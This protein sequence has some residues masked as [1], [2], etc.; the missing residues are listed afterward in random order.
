M[1]IFE[2]RRKC[3]LDKLISFIKKEAILFITALFAIVSMFFVQPGMEYLSYIDFKVLGILFC[4][5]AVVEGFK[6]IGIF[7][8]LSESLLIRTKNI[9]TVSIILVNCVF[10]SSMF[11]TNDVALITFVPITIGVFYRTKHTKL[12]FIIVMETLAANL[13]SMITPIG[14]PQNLFLYSYFNL[15]IISFF[16]YI[17]PVGILSYVIIMIIMLFSKKDIMHFMFESRARPGRNTL[18]LLEY[19]GLFILCILTVL[20]ILDYRICF[21]IVVL[22]V[23]LT[24]KTILKNVDYGLL[25]TFVCF[26]I[27]TGN[28][29]K[30][31]AVK[32]A[33]TFFIEGRVFII[34]VLSCQII[35]NVPAAMMI[36][37]FTDDVRQLLL[38]VNIGGLGTPVASLA[39]LIS[40]KIYSRSKNPAM[41]PFMGIFT[42]FNVSVLLV[43]I[44]VTVIFL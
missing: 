4:L 32:N 29:E 6:K 34:T 7:D 26:F 22:A 15:D 44:L 39:S 37:H 43:L 9:K 16:G 30:I 31:E 27:F 8:F 12:I 42:L 2:S 1:I 40:F 41:A 33:L 14:N 38:G 3:N 19:I 20:H 25:L 13:G 18:P 24:D 23:L 28:L 36:S 11:V 35:S 17:L 10:I 21:L 5:M